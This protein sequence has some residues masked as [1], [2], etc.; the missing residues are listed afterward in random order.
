MTSISF[1]AIHKH[2]SSSGKRHDVV[3]GL[4]FS[5]KPSDVIGLVGPNGAGKTTTLHLLMGHEQSDAGSLWVDELN[6]TELPFAEQKVLLRQTCSLLPENPHLPK[7]QSGKNVVLEYG[8]LDGL[9]L[10]EALEKANHI[11]TILPIQSFWEKPCL[12]YSKG[13]AGLISLARVMML[14]RDVV[15]LDEPTIG[16]DFQATQKVH[17]W[18]R[19]LSSQGKI[20]IVSSHLIN[21]LQQLTPTIVGIDQGKEAS[22]ETIR[23]WLYLDL[24]QQAPFLD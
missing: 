8:V 7:Y 19:D 3:R 20:V 4:S 6:V 1:D 11:Q 12:H 22:S 14:E 15:L 16:L 10:E 24:E 9:S 21:D 13:Q 2:F 17:T 23:T 18:I 5:A